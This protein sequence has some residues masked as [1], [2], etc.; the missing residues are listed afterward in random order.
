MKNF[1][2]WIQ[3]I[4]RGSSWN[5]NQERFSCKWQPTSLQTNWKLYPIENKRMMEVLCLD[6]LI[7]DLCLVQL[8]F[9]MNNS[10]LVRILQFSSFLK[11]SCVLKCLGTSDE[12][13]PTCIVFK[14]S[15]NYW[16]SFF[17]SLIIH[18]VS[19]F[20]NLHD[21]SLK[22][23]QNTYEVAWFRIKVNCNYSSENNTKY[24]L[25]HWQLP[26]ITSYLPSNAKKITKNI[27]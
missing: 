25:N 3:Q 18:A 24:S 23:I 15:K 7:F 13:S 22:K 11:H 14:L 16:S 10:I 26:Q 6:A 1:I 8:P 9:K 21:F 20:A 27:A 4:R 2:N 17:I 12:L 19:C 5:P